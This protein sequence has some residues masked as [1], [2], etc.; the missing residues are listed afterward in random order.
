MSR[1]KWEVTFSSKFKNSKFKF[2]LCPYKNSAVII[3]YEN[4]L[5]PG[6]YL[7]IFNFR[8]FLF[9]LLLVNKKV[10]TCFIK[11]VCIQLILNKKKASINSTALF[12]SKQIKSAGRPFLA[13][14]SHIKHLGTHLKFEITSEATNK[15]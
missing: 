3:L 10:F 1:L 7:F 13:P 15:L 4:P 5:Q 11:S 2:N 6:F 12:M 14:D 8:C 9:K